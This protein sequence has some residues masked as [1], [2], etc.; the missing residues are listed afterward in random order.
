M[1]WRGPYNRGG[2]KG[3]RAR[4][5][6]PNRKDR[7]AS[8]SRMTRQSPIL[9][10]IAVL[11][12]IGVFLRRPRVL[13][14]AGLRAGWAALGLLT[15]LHVAVLLLVILPLLAWYQNTFGLPLPDAF[16]KLP[17]GWLLPITI[18]AAP[19]L[20]EMIFRGWQS[21]RPR[22]LWLLAGLVGFAVLAAKAQAMAPMM[23]L[24]LL[25]A[26]VVATAGG[27]LWLRR[28]RTPAAWFRRAYPTLFWLAALAFAGVHLVNYP[29]VSALSV[30]MV[31][32]QLWA[33]VLLGF[34]R[35]RIGLPAAMLQHAAANGATMVLVHLGG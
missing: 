35:Q 16:G 9:S 27:W 1:K 14:P 18:L 24:G 21:G 33:G 25:A 12:D 2:G 10:P 11:R 3:N 19:V 6:Q 30:P 34:T 29:S 22:A 13:V 28:R 15:G 32:P 20:E 17:A 31:L 23:M 7:P 26:L 5:L 8:T 4:R